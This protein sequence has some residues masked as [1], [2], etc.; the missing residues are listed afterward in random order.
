MKHLLAG[1]TL[2]SLAVFASSAMADDSVPVQQPAMAGQ[3]ATVSGN[4]DQGGT[5]AGSTASG[6][7]LTRNDV[8]RQLIHA[9]QD[10][11]IAQLDKTLYKGQ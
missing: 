3:V 2:S 5:I 4:S 7:S 9:E 1:I 10:G 11:Q 8:K 6:G